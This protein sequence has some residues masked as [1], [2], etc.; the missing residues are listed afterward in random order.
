MANTMEIGSALQRPCEGHTIHMH[1]GS[2]AACI[3]VLATIVATLLLSACNDEDAPAATMPVPPTPLQQAAPAMMG[4][5]ITAYWS[6][7]GKVQLTETIYD[8]IPGVNDAGIP[9]NTTGMMLARFQTDV[10]A[11]S[12][13]VVVILGGTNDL[14]S[15]SIDISNEAEMAND[16]AAA[17]IPVILCTIPASPVLDQ[18][19]AQQW[20]NEVAA[21][22][23]A[24]GYKLADYY[25]ATLRNGVPDP[26]L[27]ISDREHPNAA[28]YARMWP[29]LQAQ[30]V[31][32]GV[33]VPA[34]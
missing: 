1:A 21:L 26:S 24:N 27:F 4:D 17:G 18:T 10:L 22:A 28:G 14:L 7:Q 3:G 11:Y 15:G 23:T 31:A 34:E 2:R 25:T 32:E 6:G 19:M 16:A 12:P 33:E 9:G 8:L 30:L 5:S 29:V 13:N 20:N